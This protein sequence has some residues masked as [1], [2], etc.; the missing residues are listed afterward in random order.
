MSVDYMVI[1]ILSLSVKVLEMLC[2]E[3]LAL[4][5]WDLK[6]DNFLSP[7]HLM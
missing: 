1:S 4:R 6:P 2:A 5:P 3:A 7:L